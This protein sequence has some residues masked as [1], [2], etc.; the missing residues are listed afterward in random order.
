MSEIQVIHSDKVHNKYIYLMFLLHPVLSMIMVFRWFRSSW[1]KNIVWLFTIFYGFTFYISPD[2][3]NDAVR[4]KEMLIELADSDMSIS[5]FFTYL[6]SETSSYIDFAQ[7][8]I[9]FLVARFTT[10]YRILFAV[11]GFL[12]GYLYSRNIWFL[13]EKSPERIRFWS[14]FLLIFFAFILGMAGING[15]RFW[16][17]TH[18]FFF[19][20]IRLVYEQR[21]IGLWIVMSCIL[22]HFSFILPCILL[23]IYRF[24]GNHLKVYF[25]FFIVSFFVSSLNLERINQVV[26]YLPEVLQSKSSSYLNEDYMKQVETEKSEKSWFFPVIKYAKTYS[27]V[28]LCIFIF[29]HRRTYL[30]DPAMRATF[31]A[32]LLFYATFNVLNFIPS[33]GRFLTLSTMVMTAAIYWV[34]VWRPVGKIRRYLAATAPWFA[35]F[36]ILQFRVM[37]GYSSYLLVFS[38]PVFSIF[39][40]PDA[41]ILDVVIK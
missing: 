17:A 19:G 41:G 2:S 23:L 15:I 16:L 40:E 28:L 13:V 11:F 14:Q 8:L 24:F 4:Y 3:S 34:S 35:F 18:L 38:N 7:P 21:K 29:W 32:A 9:T 12:Y 25:Y 26:S 37:M 36:I 20:M 27:L 6:F 5:A 33:V 22:V 39:L 10:D 30:D 1:A 31:C